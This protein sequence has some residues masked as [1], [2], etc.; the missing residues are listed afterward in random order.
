MA[1]EIREQVTEWLAGP[2]TCFL[3][4]TKRRVKHVK[5]PVIARE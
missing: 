3:I 1:D 2:E 4:G 5:H